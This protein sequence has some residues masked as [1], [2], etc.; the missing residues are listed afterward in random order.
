MNAATGAG[1]VVANAGDHA[2]GVRVVEN[3]GGGARGA[4]DPAVEI[5]GGRGN[6]GGAGAGA[7]IEGAVPGLGIGAGGQGQGIEVGRGRDHAQNADQDRR[8]SRGRRGETDKG[9]KTADRRP[10]TD[11]N[12]QESLTNSSINCAVILQKQYFE[13]SPQISSKISI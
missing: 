11:V 13:I 12:P 7:A 10:E 6:V 8:K 9:R 2:T 3:D 1:V 5:A 4:D